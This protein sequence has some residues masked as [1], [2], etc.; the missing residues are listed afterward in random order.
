M[1]RAYSQDLQIRVVRDLEGSPAPGYRR[2]CARCTAITSL[3]PATSWSATT[4]GP[5]TCSP[6]EPWEVIDMRRRTIGY[7]SQFLCVIPRVPTLDIV[8]EQT[9]RSPYQS[10]RR[11]GVGS[12]RSRPMGRAGQGRI[13]YRDRSG[14]GRDW[15][16]V[17]PLDR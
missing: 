11:A 15:P 1:T 3:T 7:V 9:V 13:E 2:C 16:R 8:A 6:A 12:G 10:V 5:S 17:R 14:R 4:V